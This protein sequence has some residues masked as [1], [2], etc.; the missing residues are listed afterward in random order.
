LENPGADE[1]II[2]RWNFKMC[3]G[4]A[5]AGLK[6]LRIGTR[7]DPVNAVINLRVP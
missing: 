5:W 1:R 3:D 7:R 4:G 6:W 2:L